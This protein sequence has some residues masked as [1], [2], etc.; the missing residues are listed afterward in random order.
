[1][2]ANPPAPEAEGAG[3]EDASP[4][5]RLSHDREEALLKD[6]CADAPER[7]LVA[8]D[9]HLAAGRDPVTGVY[10]SRENFFAGGAF[11]RFLSHHGETAGDSWL[12][13]NGDIFDFIRIMRVPETDED[14]ARWRG[15][16]KRLGEAERAQSL[17]RPLAEVERTFGLKTHDFRTVWKLLVLFRGHPAFFQGLADWAAAG[18]TLVVTRG[19]H[20]PELYWPLVRQALRDELVL[21]GAPADGITERVA[22]AQHP[23]TV[24]NLYVEH[25]HQ[26]ESM[27]RI[28]GPPVLEESPEEI[29]LPLGSFVN[30]Y[31]INHLER[32][33]PFLDNIKPVQDALLEL[34]RRRPLRIVYLYLR[35]WK[36]IRR[37]LAIPR[38]LSRAYAFLAA[39]L[40]GL[41]V[42]TV[43]AVMLLVFFPDIEAWV[44][45][46]VPLLESR[47]VRAAGTAVG[48]L[49]PGI[50]PFLVRTAQR[51]WQSVH[52][53]RELD[54]L[55]KGGSEAMDERFGGDTS[56]TA[57]DRVYAVMGHTHRQT[58]TPL[59]DDRDDGPE[60]LYVNTGTWIPLWPQDREDL[61]GQVYYS[62]ARFER[63]PDG[64]Y[65]HES[66]FWVDD[67]G[68]PR[69]ARLLDT[70]G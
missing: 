30:R 58:V 57:P 44:V 24:A 11:R 51:I 12:V 23:F 37:A 54:E 10:S 56:D 64:E 32:L 48:V 26:Y 14:Y 46:R 67:A 28:D 38:P 33:D 40:F 18:G 29:R 65:R 13:L 22:F 35:A 66:L 9:L 15:R 62:F 16:L 39:A 8:S 63:T 31:F 36:F 21:R 70:S 50:F 5:P 3:G 49:A 1:M 20:D 53:D 47:W 55:Q 34:L 59:P 43:V 42:A 61:V 17:P 41:P 45:Q 6:L 19:N 25:G 52:R 27:S 60:K 68:Q 4:V 2:T 69:S 7:I